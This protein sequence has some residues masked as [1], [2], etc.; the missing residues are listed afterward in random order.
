MNIKIIASSSAGNC[1]IVD[2][3]YSRILLDAGIRY[4]RIARH[5]LLSE[6]DGVFISH[7][8]GDHCLAAQ[9]L[10]RRGAEVYMS[11]GEMDAAGIK[12]ATPIA[13]GKQFMVG[14]WICKPFAVQH[15]TPDPLG[16]LFHSSLTGERGV[17][18]VDSAIIKWDFKNVTHYIIEANFAEDILAEGDYPEVVKDRIRRNH[19]SLDSLKTFLRTSDLSAT[20]EI[21][22]VHMSTA[23]ADEPRFVEEIQQLTGVPVYTECVERHAL[24]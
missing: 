24:K 6:V 7:S 17:Y 13:S 20:E 18:I 21:W 10:I 5:T 12:G 4:Q 16:L 22:L 11:K 14:S 3:G 9:E 8:H 15:D 2:D 23:N 19:F 1:I